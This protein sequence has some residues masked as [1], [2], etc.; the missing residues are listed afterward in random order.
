M[1]LPRTENQRVMANRI[2]D[3][4]QAWVTCLELHPTLEA[5]LQRII[6]SYGPA[7]RPG[8]QAAEVAVFLA[9]M[10]LP[11]EAFKHIEQ[12]VEAESNYR[13]PRTWWPVYEAI[14]DELPMRI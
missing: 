13:S 14:S 11:S 4:V 5:F 2:E 1:S 9:I 10:G 7:P 8:E 12:A 6:D 3:D